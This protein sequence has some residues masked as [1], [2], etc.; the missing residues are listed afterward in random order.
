MAIPETRFLVPRPDVRP[1]AEAGA[2][3][4]TAGLD[5]GSEETP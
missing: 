4:M 2:D 3:L 1:F 5:S